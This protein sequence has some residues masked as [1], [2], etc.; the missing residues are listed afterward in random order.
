[1]LVFYRYRARQANNLSL[2]TPT[3]TFPNSRKNSNIV[4]DLSNSDSWGDKMELNNPAN[5]DDVETFGQRH[6]KER[7]RKEERRQRNKE[8][9]LNSRGISSFLTDNELIGALGFKVPGW[10]WH[11]DASPQGLGRQRVDIWGTSDS[12][13][14]LVFIEVERNRSASIFNVA[15]AWQYVEHPDS[16]PVLL[17]QLF[18]PYY[19][20][21]GIL[22]TRMNQA[23][24]VGEK[25]MS[26][27][28]SKLI[29]KSLGPDYWPESTGNADK[30]I[31]ALVSIISY[32]NL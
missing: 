2:P 7:K 3:L 11:L 17:I 19:H 9:R 27:T 6:E 29:Y 8:S 24:F 30:M 26:V 31:D 14:H 12:K 15:K 13:G 25:A 28:K 22:R 1:M 4:D 32:N 21:T 23:I 5:V 20:T 16:K 18:S 10:Q